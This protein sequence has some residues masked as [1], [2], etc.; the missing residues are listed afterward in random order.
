MKYIIAIVV[1]ILLLLGA[2]EVYGDYTA[3]PAETFLFELDNSHGW[4][5]E[6]FFWYTDTK[7]RSQAREILIE[8]LNKILS[9]LNEK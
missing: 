7:S 1:G 6:Y 9:I 8:D 2:K 3:K 5:N 4:N